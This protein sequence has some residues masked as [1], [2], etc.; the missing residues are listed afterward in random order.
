MSVSKTASDAIP[1]TLAT[2]RFR[3]RSVGARI[4]SYL[5][6][7]A[8]PH[9]YAIEAFDERAIGPA[10]ACGHLAIRG[11]LIEAKRRGVAIERLDLRNSGDT[12]GDKQIRVPTHQ[13]SVLVA[14]CR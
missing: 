12:A 2:S 1:P 3:C 14:L 7:L 9:L 4:A 11:A 6:L 5:S 8:A 13:N 10:D